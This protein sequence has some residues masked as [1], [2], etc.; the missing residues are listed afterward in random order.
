MQ[1]PKPQAPNIFARQRVAAKFARARMRQTKAGAASFLSDAI[2]E[3]LAER[4]DFMQLSPKRALVIGD[5][6]GSLSKGLNAMGAQVT[7]GLLGEFDEEVPQVAGETFDIILHS[8]G[9]GMVNDLP[10]AL[11]HARHSLAENGL[12][13]A[14]FPGAGS[15]PVLRQL[16]LVADGDRPAARMHPLVDNRAG[17]ALLERAGFKRQ[18]VDSC[19]LNVRYSSL[20]QLVQD[21]R[22]HGLT[23]SLTSAAPQLTRDGWTKAKDA[24]DALRDADGKVTERFELLTLTGWR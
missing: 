12:F 19:P 3:D 1:S 23:A 22:D 21:L 14:A 10:G 6:S 13:F 11:I 4:M 9:L 2:A 7:N 17:T 24:F 8:I 20:Y 15:L 5:G 16:A 18:V